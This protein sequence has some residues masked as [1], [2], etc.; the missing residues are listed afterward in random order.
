MISLGLLETNSIARGVIAA[1]AMLKAEQ[2]ISE[3]SITIEAQNRAQQLLDE[4][5]QECDR[6]L[7]ATT[8]ECENV[9]AKTIEDANKMRESAYSYSMGVIQEVGNC[10]SLSYS[11]MTKTFD[12]FRNSMQSS[13]SRVSSAM[14]K[15]QG[16]E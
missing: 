9:K 16:N 11:E 5:H 8:E 4:T 2:L 7:D 6:M 10:I 13:H 1:D 12:E 3:N 14:N 15:L